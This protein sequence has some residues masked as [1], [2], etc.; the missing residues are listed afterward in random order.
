LATYYVVN[1]LTFHYYIC[2]LIYYSIASLSENGRVKF[3]LYIYIIWPEV[4]EPR[5]CR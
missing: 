2:L 1:L 4:K 3:I 5:H